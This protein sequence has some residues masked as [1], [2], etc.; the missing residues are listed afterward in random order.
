[1][2]RRQRKTRDAIFRALITLLSRKSFNQITVGEIID[3]ANV[4]RATFYAHFETKDF[5]LKEFCEE[6]FVHVFESETGS[7]TAH[8]HIFDCEAPD[9]VFLH[10]LQHVK[11]NDNHILELL[12]SWNNE[13]FLGYFKENLKDLVKG[14]LSKLKIQKPAS[15]PEDFWVN[16]ISAAF[17]ETVTWWID[18]KLTQSPEEI[19]EYFLLAIHSSNQ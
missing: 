16:H 15:L 3:L 7:E 9:S 14:Q 19:N 13:L 10:L 12:S 11:K 1:M 8:N 2:D 18:H 5:L 17:V 6:L 4:G